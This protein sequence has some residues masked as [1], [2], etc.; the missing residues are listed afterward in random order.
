MMDLHAKSASIEKIDFDKPNRLGTLMCVLT[1][2]LTFG[3]APQLPN[4]TRG[5][6]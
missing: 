2:P 1:W 5:D 4:R 3:F 6:A